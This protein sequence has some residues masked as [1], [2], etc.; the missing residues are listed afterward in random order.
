MPDI[1]L[2]ENISKLLKVEA[3]GRLD[4]PDGSYLSQTATAGIRL[5]CAAGYKQDWTNGANYYR[6]QASEAVYYTDMQDNNPTDGSLLLS[7]FP[8]GCLWET[9][10]GSLYTSIGD[11]T[12]AGYTDWSE[13]SPATASVWSMALSANAAA[14]SAQDTANAAQSAASA[15]QSTA[16]TAL[17]DAATAQ[18][19]ANTRARGIEIKTADFTAVVG[20]RY[21]TE[22]GSIISITDPTG[23]TAGQSYEVWIGSGTIWFNGAGTVYSA[24][25]FSIRRRYNGSAWVTPTPVLTDELSLAAYKET[26]SNPSF[27]AG[28]YTVNLSAGTTIF[29]MSVVEN[30]TV[31]LP[32]ATAGK[33]FMMEMRQTGAF[34]LAWTPAGG[35]IVRWQ[36]NITPV[37]TATSGRCDVF[38]FFCPIAGVWRASAVQN[39]TTV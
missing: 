7:E 34:T 29:V 33:S 19:N 25:R 11:L 31:T 18:A 21:I 26:A 37:L 6:E 20:G 32:T 23:T 35:D 3:G 2:T 17:S 16:N 8:I 4:F 22:S 24:S 28:S 30:S 10:D 12:E 15:A 27:T 38:S 39:Y 1:D 13:L 36:N 9:V 14:S 5:V